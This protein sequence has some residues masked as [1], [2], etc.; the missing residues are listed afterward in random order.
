MF[1]IRPLTNRLLPLATAVA[2]TVAVAPAS[3]DDRQLLWGD[4]HLHSS[5]SFD[6]YLFRNHSADPDTAYR[7]AKGLPVIH[8]FHR[9]R[10]KIKQPLDFLTVADHAEMMGVVR[11]LG[12]G[13][14]KLQKIPIARK[15]MQWMKA[16]KG[17]D[18]FAELVAGA[19]GGGSDPGMEALSSSEVR[20]GFWHE[21]VDATERHNQ[22]GKFT[23]FVGWEWS[24]MNL[25][26]NLHRIVLT[27][28]G[29]DKAKQILPYSSLDSSRAEDLWA[30]MQKTSTALDMDMLAIPH[31]PNIS[32]GE[33]FNSVDTE[34]RPL[35][36]EYARTRMRWEPVA[37]ITQIKGDSETHPLLSPGDE[38]AEFESYRHLIDTRP[39][40][41]KTAPVNEGSY[42]RSALKRGLLQEQ[43]LGVNP[44]K[45]GFIGSTDSHSGLASAEENNF[46]GKMALDGTPESK[47][48]FRV[49]KQGASGWDMSASGLAAVWAQE[50]TRQSIMDAFKRREVYASSGP[51]ISVRMF[52]GWNFKSRD[53]KRKN[54][55][56]V[57]Y[58]KGVPMGGDLS[59]A[60]KRKSP[61]FIIQ[62]A[63]DP[64][65]ANLDRIQIVKGYLD[66]A[67]K[68]QE[69]VFNVAASGQRKLSENMEA[70]GNTVDLNTGKYNNDIGSES[71]QAFWRDPEFN[72]EQRAFY[73]A[74]VLEIPT[75]R[76]TT[77]DKIALGQPP[78][79]GKET[80]QERA[81]TSPVW[82][83]PS[84][85]NK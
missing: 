18:V 59:Q 49:G 41:N 81:Y 35:T 42:L 28:A 70:V 4:T 25:G 54:F 43:K 13:D 17:A 48:I 85:S 10:V 12:L 61:S 20:K 73:Y 31:N 40:V 23:T 11:G 22:P 16:G 3:A 69:K 33:M 27:S 62:A 45:L 21:I 8:P 80:L 67:G 29:A 56:D 82:Y 72:S 26:A 57:G 74:R 51:R 34:G 30:W 15:Y 14:K 60:P 47:D 50:N 5:Y 24:S 36:A 6:A 19:N 7:Y 9:G 79:E 53:A 32:K 52:A 44:F 77:F 68:A 64:R 58:R 76:H 71:L 2:A 75:P 46:Q 37:E 55:A 66:D 78:I 1:D 39:G 65:G 84:E 63:R 83:T 38:F